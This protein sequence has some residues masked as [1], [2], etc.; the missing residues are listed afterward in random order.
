M[1]AVSGSSRSE[2][3]LAR[4]V[5]E[6]AAAA[7]GLA[8]VAGAIAADRAWLDRHFLPPFFA[9][10]IVYVLTASVARLM[11]AALG[12]ALAFVARPRIGRFAARTPLTTLAADAIRVVLAVALALGASELALRHTVFGLAA[13]EMP[14]TEEPSRQRN[15]R[16]GWTFVP[17]RTGRDTVG[18]RTIEYAFDPAGY[19][20]RRADR[21]VDP[22]RPTIIF[23]GESV[24]VGQGLTWEETVPAQVEA[25]LGIQSANIAVHGYATDQAYMR[26]AAE[27]PRFRRPVAVVLLFAPA[28]FDRNLDRDRPHLGPGLNWLPAERR[29]SLAELVR[30]LVPYHSDD[31]IDRGIAATRAV[32]RATIDL[33]RSRGAT[34]IILVPQFAPEDP[35]ERVLRRRILDEIQLPYVRVELDPSWRVPN[36][37]HPDARAAHA[38]ALG[39]VDRLRPR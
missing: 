16:L 1:D 32:L 4:V 25:L 11:V 13:Q 24:M 8:L 12:L 28:L 22:E 26:L 14:T 31:A 34:P 37:R 2:R 33:A 29:T 27:L 38:M 3:T 30:W 36:D 39:V 5:V 10:R 9:P 15:E 6:V 19:R 23:T 35:T 20:V 21:P 7:T 18:G 17:A